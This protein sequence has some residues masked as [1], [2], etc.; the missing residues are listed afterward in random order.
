MIPA[1]IP[2]DTEIEKRW[3][4]HKQNQVASIPRGIIW[5]QNRLLNLGFKIALMMLW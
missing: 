1:M 5:K 4:G 3:D 2:A